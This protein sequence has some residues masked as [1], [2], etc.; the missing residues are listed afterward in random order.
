VL[1]SIA[2]KRLGR[3]AAAELLKSLAG[4]SSDFEKASFLSENSAQFLSDER[5]RS[6]YF[7]IVS[8]IGSDF[9]HH[10]VLSSLARKGGLNEQTLREVLKS[11]SAIQSDFEKASFLIE[12]SALFVESESLRPS[13][14]G[15]VRT[16]KSDFERN[17]VVSNLSRKHR[18]D[19]SSFR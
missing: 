4:I 16:I 19:F 5:L 14:F 13:F 17:R 1:T 12:S 6:A 7:D 18:T 15:V 11:A 3:D 8:T 10:R 2:K 9:E